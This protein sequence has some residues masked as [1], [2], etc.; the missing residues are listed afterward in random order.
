MFFN[1][2]LGIPLV[3]FRIFFLFKI[4]GLPFLFEHQSCW[5]CKNLSFYWIAHRVSDLVWFNHH[6]LWC[7]P[8]HPSVSN[9]EAEDIPR[10]TLPGS[11]IWPFHCQKAHTRTLNVISAVICHFVFTDVEKPASYSFCPLCVTQNDS[12]TVWR[13]QISSESH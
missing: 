12:W 13:P 8:N 10:Q 1:L 9:E 2:T 7:G 3:N 5:G 11:C 6:S 4:N